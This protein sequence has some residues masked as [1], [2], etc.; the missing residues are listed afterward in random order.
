MS[1]LCLIQRKVDRQMWG[2]GRFCNVFLELEKR[3]LKPLKKLLR[4]V[5]VAE[6]ERE[7]TASPDKQT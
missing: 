1:R 2:R 5:G 7:R 4:C 3:K 6:K